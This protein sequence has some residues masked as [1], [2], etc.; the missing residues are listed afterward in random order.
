MTPEQ[1]QT[2]VD[3]NARLRDKLLEVA[4]ECGEC[5]GTG[6]VTARVGN[7]QVDCPSCLDIRELL[8]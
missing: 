3:E 1:V 5:S 4:E 6:V 2:V 8:Q 7:L